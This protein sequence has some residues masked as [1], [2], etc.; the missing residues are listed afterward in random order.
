MKNI[1]SCG[2]DVDIYSGCILDEYRI[3]ML[4]N[5]INYSQHFN[6]ALLKE[7]RNPVE[8]N[9]DMFHVIIGR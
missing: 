2:G 5:E 3:K 9:F 6:I 8:M 1:Q 7:T 4:S